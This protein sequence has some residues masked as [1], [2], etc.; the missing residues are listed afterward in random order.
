MTPTQQH[1]A[2]VREFAL[3]NAP[4][5]ADL[6]ALGCAFDA[7]ALCLEEL[8]FAAEAR[9]EIKRVAYCL[10]PTEYLTIDW[11][12]ALPVWRGFERVQGHPIIPGVIFKLKDSA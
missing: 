4:E 5:G 6:D 2:D 1:F 11:A 3:A 8:A 9:Y 12:K 10:V 7:G